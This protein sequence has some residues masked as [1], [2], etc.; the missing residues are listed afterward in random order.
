MSPKRIGLVGFDGVTAL[1]VVGAADA[2]TAAALDDGYGNR[3]ACYEVWTLGVDCERFHAESGV[4]LTARATLAAAPD[5][6]TILVAGGSGIRWPGVADA[7]A[8]WLIKRA[9]TTRRIGAACAG[10]YA[11]A[12]T[13]LLDGREVTTHWRLA[14]DIGRRFPRLKLNHKR[15]L[16]RDGTF[17]TA[18]GLSAGINLPLALVEEDYGRHLA[19]AVARELVVHTSGQERAL[20]PAPSRAPTQPIDRFADLVAW[21]MHNLHADLSVE[22]LARRACMCPD[23][24]S[25]AFKSVMGEPPS[26]F[27][28]NLRLHEAQRRLTRSN[29]TVESV[30]ASVGFSNPAAFQR[31]FQRKFGARPSRCLQSPSRRHSSENRAE[32]KLPL[33]SAA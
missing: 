20:A 7:I 10:I 24:F 17:Y 25:K 31:A 3:I 16:V 21:I 8:E 28:E 9:P 19:Q 5:F 11:L 14:T 12:A 29:K 26:C 33:A 2:F 27:V 22:V 15:T 4:L 1:H 32:R 13:G 23:H 18:A 30:A 6:D